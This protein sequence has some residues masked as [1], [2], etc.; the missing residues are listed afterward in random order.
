MKEWHK[1]SDSPILHRRYSFWSFKNLIIVMNDNKHA[2]VGDSGNKVVCFS[3][4]LCGGFYPNFI[5]VVW[6]RLRIVFFEK[7]TQCLFQ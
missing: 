1:E 6:Q 5:Q 2:T 7:P 3:Q 4:H